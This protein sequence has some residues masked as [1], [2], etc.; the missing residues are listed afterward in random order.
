MAEVEGFEPT[1]AR[2]PVFKTG[3][4]DRYATLPWLLPGSNS[5][6]LSGFFH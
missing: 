5:T 1:K 2:P 4:I 3:A 6:T